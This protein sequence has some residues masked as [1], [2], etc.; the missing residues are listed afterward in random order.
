MKI[1]WVF[2][3]LSFFS[4]LIQTE[5]PADFSIVPQLIRSDPCSVSPFPR[6]PCSAAVIHSNQAQQGR[7]NFLCPVFR[8][9]NV[10]CRSAADTQLPPCMRRFC[11]LFGFL[12]PQF[13]FMCLCMHIASMKTKGVGGLGGRCGIRA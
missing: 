13:H 5:I 10:M 11:F 3:F 9:D 12:P 6:P 8:G 1:L 2:F 4:L 7:S